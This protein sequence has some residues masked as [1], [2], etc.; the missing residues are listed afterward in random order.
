MNELAQILTMW[1]ERFMPDHDR[2][3][4]LFGLSGAF[5]VAAAAPLFDRLPPGERERMAGVLA[6]PDRLDETAITHAER[7]VQAS[8]RQGDVLGPHAALQ[9][10]M[11]QRRMFQGILQAKPSGELLRRSQSVYAELTQ[12]VGW[13]LFNIGD[14]QAAQHYYDEARTA[15]HDAQNVELVT[16]ILCTMSHLA[17]WQ[18]KPRVGIDHAVAAEVWAR[19]SQSPSAL[20]YASDVAARAYAADGEWDACDEALDT[21][22]AALADIPT[23]APAGNWWYFYDESFYWATKSGCS[24]LRG[25]PQDALAANAQALTLIDSTN[26]HNRAFTLAFQSEAL[27]Q[28][29]EISE[30]C[31][32]LSGVVRMT[33][34]HKS[35]RVDQCILELRDQMNTRHGSTKDVAELDETL[36]TY[37]DAS[38]LKGRRN[39]S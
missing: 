33:A 31:Q 32:I 13:L 22:R 34:V 27:M 20:A 19:R 15:A 6:D 8:R 35:R 2:R 4:L 30:A 23:A 28:Q 24:L 10:V 5:A 16:Y 26:L 7:M 21:E 38:L 9:V 12:L 25:R 36:R 18:G 17:T 1:A 11:A 39:N 37:R 14:Y 3:T 29:G